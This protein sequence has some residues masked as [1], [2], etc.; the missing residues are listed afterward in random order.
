MKL[1]MRVKNKIG[2]SIVINLSFPVHR[3]EIT[4]F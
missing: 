1:F 3:R 2:L 4:R